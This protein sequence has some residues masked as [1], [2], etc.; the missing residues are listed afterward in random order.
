MRDI[1]VEIKKCTDLHPQCNFCLS[2]QNIYNVRGDKLSFVASI[3]IN[4][5]T[6]IFEETQH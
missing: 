3:C 4:C 6:K 2:K 1:K 5:I